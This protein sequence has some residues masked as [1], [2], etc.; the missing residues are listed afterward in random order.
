MGAK[1]TTVVAQVMLL[2]IELK[3]EQPIKRKKAASLVNSE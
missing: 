3:F 1:N 2:V